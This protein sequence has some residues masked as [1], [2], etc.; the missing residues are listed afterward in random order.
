MGFFVSGPF[1]VPLP[2]PPILCPASR[3]L[4]FIDGPSPRC[5]ANHGALRPTGRGC[6]QCEDDDLQTHRRTGWSGLVNGA[7]CRLSGREH[8]EPAEVGKPADV[9][10]AIAFLSSG[11]AAFIQGASL[12]VDGG[13]HCRL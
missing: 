5:R 9:A 7:G 6:P 13:R 11:E 1:L 8:G 4:V 2:V 10:A 12:L 3:Q